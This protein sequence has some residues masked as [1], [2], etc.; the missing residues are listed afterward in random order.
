VWT[1]DGGAYRL[2]GNE[3][4]I[5]GEGRANVEE[6][7]EDTLHLVSHR[8]AG[9]L[10]L[11][12]WH[13]SGTLSFKLEN[14]AHGG[15]GPRET[16]AFLVV[17]PE[18]AAHV[19]VGRLLRP[20][21]L[22]ELA[23]GAMDPSRAR[24]PAAEPRAAADGSVPTRFRIMTY[25][26]HGCRGMDGRFSVERITRVLA[27]ALPDVVCLQELDQ[28]RARSGR[29]DQVHEIA[30]RLAKA[31]KF[32]AVSEVDDGRFGN[33]VLSSHPLRLV[34]SGPLPVLGKRLGLEARGVL[35]VEVD[36]DGI[37]VQ[38]LNT[39]LSILD[40]E[41]RL[42]VATLVEWAKRARERGPVLLAGD[43]NA[44]RDSYTGRRLAS[45]LHDVVERDTEARA[46]GEPIPRT[47]FGRVP[48]RRIDH[49]FAS[50]QLAVRR[51]EVPR[52]RLART[53][54]DH[55]PVVVDLEVAGLAGPH[56]AGSQSLGHDGADA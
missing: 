51:V 25:N 14:G 34:D 5:F 16:G 15:P 3:R 22:R 7:V 24:L 56:V 32:H 21:D 26:V 53:A 37:A 43:L 23:F 1:A 55:L 28:E 48:M 36:V 18:T 40:R 54:S 44:T 52:S 6:L 49:V 33:A 46:A 39:H 38:V 9:E 10:V 4:E 50:D 31:Y 12:S 20:L 27:R 30:T 11:W 47:W 42:Q 17:P 2:P 45:I 8:N 19:P 29:F 13:P 35:W 41:R